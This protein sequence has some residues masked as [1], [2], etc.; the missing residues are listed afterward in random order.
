MRKAHMF[1]DTRAIGFPLTDAINAHVE[2]RLVSTLA[3]VRQHVTAVTARLDDM[4]AGRGGIDKRCRVSAV[5]ARK[6]TVV[7][8]A[9]CVDLYEAI[10]QATKRLRR[11]VVRSIKRPV[12]RER[13][14][15]QRP[16]VLVPV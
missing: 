9:T 16:G 7:A 5:V 12:A 1:I 3:P 2:S 4:N 11:S 15:S 10:D 6:S 13:K 14:N 8:V